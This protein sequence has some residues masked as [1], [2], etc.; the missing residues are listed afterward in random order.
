M[1]LKLGI[2]KP[3]ALGNQ[4]RK[5]SKAKQAEDLKKEK[6]RIEK[7]KAKKRKLAKSEAKIMFDCLKQEF[8]I[9]A[10]KGRYDWYC[11]FDYFTKIMKENNLHSDEYYLYEEI[12]KICEQNKIRT[13]SPLCWDKK[14]KIY[15]FYWD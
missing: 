9:A 11:N 5:M 10:K 6:A 8:V 15:D 13:S 2:S 1:W 7:E 14:N 3:K 12:K 4:L